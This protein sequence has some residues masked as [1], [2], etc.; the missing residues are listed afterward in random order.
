MISIDC[1][2]D[3]NLNQQ[4][5]SELQP[6]SSACICKTAAESC[7]TPAHAST[8]CQPAARP[9][10]ASSASTK[11]RGG[12]SRAGPAPVNPQPDPGDKSPDQMQEK[13]VQQCSNRCKELNSVLNQLH[14]RYNPELH[15]ASF[16]DLQQRQSGATEWRPG[17]ARFRNGRSLNQKTL[18]NPRGPEALKKTIDWPALL[19][20]RQGF[21]GPQRGARGL[22]S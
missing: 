16:A 11:G 7:R 17:R 5:R 13:R 9:C 3:N 2:H 18:N 21:R 22:R 1:P 4:V 14:L 10:K 19:A 6:G 15:S 12:L 8:T 20:R